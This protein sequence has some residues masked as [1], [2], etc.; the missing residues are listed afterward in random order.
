MKGTIKV[1]NKKKLRRRGLPK[2]VRV[3][4]DGEQAFLFDKH[5]RQV[6]VMRTA[7]I[8]TTGDGETSVRADKVRPP[9]LDGSFRGTCIA[10]I[11]PT[12][13]AVVLEGC[14]NFMHAV[15]GLWGIPQETI[16]GTLDAGLDDMPKDAMVPA[17]VDENGRIVGLQQT[18][19][20][21]ADCAGK[22][23][24]TAGLYINGGRPPVY[25]ERNLP[26]YDEC[27]HGYGEPS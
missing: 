5:D 6:G 24:M 19:R 12:D 7:D 8:G 21:C 15:L 1:S 10:C 4:R 20:V 16:Q 14:V 18:F 3:R 23:S 13:T 26:G 27:D 9:G 22:A 25:A 11:E 17:L 2:Q